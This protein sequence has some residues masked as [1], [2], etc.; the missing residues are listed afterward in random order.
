MRNKI[1][2][3]YARRKVRNVKFF[4]GQFTMAIWRRRE[5][6]LGHF[7]NGDGCLERTYQGF[8]ILPFPTATARQSHRKQINHHFSSWCLVNFFKK[9]SSFTRIL[10][11][12]VTTIA[13][14]VVQRMAMN[15]SAADLIFIL[16]HRVEVGVF[17][18]DLST[19]SGHIERWCKS[20][21]LDGKISDLAVV[22][23]KST[24]HGFRIQL[25]EK[26]QMIWKSF[27]C[28][29]KLSYLVGNCF[30]EPS[31]KA[32]GAI[33]QENEF[34]IDDNRINWIDVQKKDVNLPM[35]IPVTP[36]MIGKWI[37]MAVNWIN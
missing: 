34:K 11:G 24:G 7:Y 30:S 4:V 29:N 20:G 1:D 17:V 31:S 22:R 3:A 8:R 13:R 36:A 2:C 26:F 6:I 18:G 28:K 32:S 9:V 10:G 5:H 27:S 21:V 19:Q 14:L 25:D 33:W 35:N 23:I 15:Q 37:Q 12:K 16:M